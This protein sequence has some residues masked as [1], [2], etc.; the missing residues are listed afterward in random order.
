M[1]YSRVRFP[2]KLQWNSTF[3]NSFGVNNDFVSCLWYNYMPSLLCLDDLWTSACFSFHIFY[4]L[5]RPSKEPREKS[6]F[7]LHKW[8]KC[9]VTLCVYVCPCFV[10]CKIFTLY[11]KLS[12][13]WVP[14]SCN[15]KDWVK[16]QVL[17][18]DPTKTILGMAYS[19]QKRTGGAQEGTNFTRDWWKWQGNERVWD[20][21]M[22]W[23][24]MSLEWDINLLVVHSS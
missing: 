24:M 18:R 1:K 6:T 22:Q 10:H 21:V 3:I 23:N 19:P 11:D 8:D 16:K 5:C 13:G 20:I 17:E 9:S 12:H 2:T 7:V 14:N 15:G 4:E